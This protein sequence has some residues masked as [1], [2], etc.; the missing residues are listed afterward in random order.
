M[1]KLITGSRCLRGG[2]A[3]PRF[4]PASPVPI[5]G[6]TI[7]CTRPLPPLPVERLLEQ[8]LAVDAE[9]RASFL[10][11]A[12]EG[13]DELLA[14]MVSLVAALA[15]STILTGA[16]GMLTAPLPCVGWEDVDISTMPPLRVEPGGGRSPQPGAFVTVRFR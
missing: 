16:I 12:C 14:E 10:R 5:V 7:M 6:G 9:E 3:N 1:L 13:D 4:N 11:V 15:M 8:T 2:R